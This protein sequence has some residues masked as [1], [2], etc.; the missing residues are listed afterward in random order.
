MMQT[1]G[2]SSCSRVMCLV[3]YLKNLKTYLNIRIF[4]KKC[5]HDITN[6]YQLHIFHLI[7]KKNNNNEKIII[8]NIT[9]M[10]SVP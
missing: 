7:T 9:I 3:Y 6:K 10:L 4:S 1:T 8:T 2:F 5:S